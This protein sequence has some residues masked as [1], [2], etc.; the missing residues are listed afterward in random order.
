MIAYLDMGKT[1]RDLAIKSSLPVED[2]CIGELNWSTFC[3]PSDEAPAWRLY[4]ELVTRVP[5]VILPDD[6]GTELGALDS[7]YKLFV[8]TRDA[9]SLVGHEAQAFAVIA[10]YLLN[11]VLRDFMAMW[12]RRSQEDGFHNPRVAGQ[13]RHELGAI[14]EK[15]IEVAILLCALSGKEEIFLARQVCARLVEA[16]EPS[17]QASTLTGTQLTEASCSGS[18]RSIESVLKLE[19]AEIS[20]RRLI[21]NN[22]RFPEKAGFIVPSIRK[23][24]DQVANQG[25]SIEPALTGVALSGGGIRSAAVCLGVSQALDK[26]GIWKQVDYLSSVS[27][28]GYLAGALSAFWARQETTDFSVIDFRFPFTRDIQDGRNKNPGESVA[29][30]T[31]RSRSSFL[32]LHFGGAHFVGL[33]RWFSGIVFILALCGF[34]L[35]LPSQIKSLIGFTL[36]IVG[37]ISE[38]TILSLLA[39]ALLWVLCI[40]PGSNKSAR[41]WAL[42]FIGWTGSQILTLIVLSVVYLRFGWEAL[43]ALGL[44]GLAFP[45]AALVTALLKT[46]FLGLALSVLARALPFA[47]TVSVIFMIESLFDSRTVTLGYLA[48]GGVC[49]FLALIAGPN[50]MSLHLFYAKQLTYAFSL[51]KNGIGTPS[52]KLSDIGSRFGPYH[53]INGSISYEEKAGTITQSAATD[54]RPGKRSDVFIFSQLFCGSE[55]TGFLETSKVERSNRALNLATAIAASAAAV[56]PTMGNRTLRPYSRWLM[57]LNVRLALWLNFSEKPPVWWVRQLAVIRL[58]LAEF[59]GKVSIND[60]WKHISDGGHSDNLAVYSLL[61]RRCR[62]IIAVDAECDSQF[63]FSGLKDTDR[64]ARLNLSAE[65]VLPETELQ[66]IA[67]GHRCFAVGKINYLGGESGTL[68]YIKA[69]AIRAMHRIPMLYAYSKATTAFPHESTLD[70]FFTEEQFEAYRSLGELM[71]EEVFATSQT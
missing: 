65:I 71:G 27:G 15:T 69:T 18:Q 19:L 66:D 23:A 6:L 14:R 5:I 31:L 36:P 22:M 52:L 58:S 46:K 49:L 56:S 1:L 57:F 38:T 50:G 32:L 61:K 39:G 44:I 13:F 21:K 9:V 3:T 40:L 64:L 70:Q 60:D 8:S 45:L 68:I 63:I 37:A 55:G 42:S 25:G 17:D 2:I 33:L 51:S 62:L 41:A 7:I 11:E 47:L 67:A 59:F 54:A 10:E 43:I 20:A 4:W 30:R 53:L 48:S 35:M 26:A 16:S 24:L 12:H 34:A 28:G 29:L